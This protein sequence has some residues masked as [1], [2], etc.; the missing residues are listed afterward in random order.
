MKKRMITYNDIKNSPKYDKV[1]IFDKIKYYEIM[2]EDYS[3]LYIQY[4][5]DNYGFLALNRFLRHDTDYYH[6]FGMD[7]KELFYDYVSYIEYYYK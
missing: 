4:I 5:E 6:R 7:D 3:A 2:G 1:N